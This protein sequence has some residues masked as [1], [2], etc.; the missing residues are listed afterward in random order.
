MSDSTPRTIRTESSPELCEQIS[1]HVEA[2]VLGIVERDDGIV[3]A[4]PVP[5]IRRKTLEDV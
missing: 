3:R 1:T 4:G 5:D 2:I